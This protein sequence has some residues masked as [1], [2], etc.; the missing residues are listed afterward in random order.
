MAHKPLLRQLL[1]WS[2]ISIACT[3][4]VQLGDDIAAAVPECAQDCVA[5][6]IEANFPSVKCESDYTLQCLCSAPSLSGFTIGEGALQC[7]IGEETVGGC[8]GNEVGTHATSTALTMCNGQ[9]SAMPR[10]HTLLTAS[11]VV[12]STGGV[13]II[14]PTV[15]SVPASTT[16]SSTTTHSS[17]ATT[18]R[19]PPVTSTTSHRSTSAAS[20]TSTSTG[21]QP[22]Q[23]TGSASSTA[24]LSGGQIAGITV[25]VAG[26]LVIAALAIFC[27][28]RFRK[29]RYVVG[30]SESEKGFYQAG[31][32]RYTPEP[33]GSRLSRIFHIS[34][35][36]LRTS[37]YSPPNISMPV[38]S[39]V[40][41]QASTQPPPR[42][43]TLPYGSTTN[44]DRDTI[45]LAISRPRSFLPQ[46]FSRKSWL[47]S[48]TSSKMEESQTAL[49]RKPS[50][51]LPPRPALTIDIPRPTA[52]TE[53]HS[54]L[55]VPTTNRES[56]MTNMTA[57][58]DLDTEAAEG[59]QIWRPPPTDPLSA[60]TLY[61]ADKYGNWVLSNDNR[62]SQVA[63]VVEAAELDTY[64]PLTKSPI[65]K[66]EEAAR[67][68]AAISAASALPKAP[69]PAF[70]SQ[71]PADASRSSSMY[72]QASVVRNSRGAQSSRSNSNKSRKGS[73]GGV[74]QLD[75]AVSSASATTIATT[76]TTFEDADVYEPDIG[77]LSTLSPVVES[78][79]PASGRSRVNYPKIPG[80]LGGATMRHVPPPRRPNFIPGSPPG[81][82]SPT[83]GISFPVRD[84][85]G[86]YPAPLRPNRPE[87]VRPVMQTTGSGFTPE[88]PNVVVF[89]MPPRPR[90]VPA[91]MQTPPPRS[92]P[93]FVNTSGQPTVDVSPLSDP[94]GTPNPPSAPRPGR[95]RTPPQNERMTLSP[96]PPTAT[97]LSEAP[98][99]PRLGLDTRMPGRPRISTQSPM[100]GTTT[101]SN[102]SSLLAKRLGSDR[103]AALALDPNGSKKRPGQWM[104]QGDGGLLS[105]DAAGLRSPLGTAGTLPMT[106]T[107]QPKLTPTRR[108]E[109]L[110]LSVQ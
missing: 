30:D 32:D 61:I 60:T 50:R 59:A 16:H 22:T 58:A 68:A 80:R 81:Q 56:T 14:L 34:P 15:S 8:T 75:R 6:F 7:I 93:Q 97:S 77:R 90:P 51:L 54:S 20:S 83:L 13:S 53:V 88:P 109:D 35:P 106:P 48:P 78:P 62:R 38:P 64:T 89:P 3:S 110:F 41:P 82:P 99:P 43:Q 103:A 63:Q 33:P 24:K 84:S 72:S 28:G 12:P 86:A 94:S 49:E 85:P 10:T 11:F 18:T 40:S 101:S 25:G 57:F 95:V 55:A 31:S 23:S 96:T 19:L 67:M 69:K 73:G 4:S 44:V 65:E 26:A 45:G 104:R 100:S 108:G 79:S 46:R 71:D 87:S 70:L 5:S 2:S 66:R 36:V 102:T 39:Q 1:I 105:P 76:S 92:Q 29:R 74:G 98:T 42:Q 21:S 17:F 47:K 27:A 9:V 91:K 37:K 107:W 52:V